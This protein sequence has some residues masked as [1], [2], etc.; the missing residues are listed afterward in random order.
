[1]KVQNVRGS[2]NCA[3]ESTE[4]GI[5]FK[6]KSI[7]CVCTPTDE[8]RGGKGEPNDGAEGEKDREK[9]KGG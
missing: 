5:C 2:E 1:M 6:R 4:S 8:E 3:A 9:G 7:Q